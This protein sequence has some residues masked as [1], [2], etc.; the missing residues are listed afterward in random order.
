MDNL[1][2]VIE[3]SLFGV[4]QYLGVKLSMPT[5]QIRKYFIYSSLLTFGSPLIIYL[6]MAFW[7]R[8]RYYFKGRRNPVW[9]Q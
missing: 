7:M 2:N 8:I 6:I 4:C 5:A 9:D 3:S 1:R